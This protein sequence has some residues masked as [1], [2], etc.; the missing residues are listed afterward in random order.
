MIRTWQ[1]SWFEEGLRLFY[2]LPRAAVDAVLPLTIN[3]APD[4][5]T[6]VFV[7]RAELITPDM[8]R[9]ALE[10]VLKDGADPV[11]AGKQL[12]TFGRFRNVVLGR[13]YPKTTDEAVRKRIAS[14][15]G[16]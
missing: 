14:L 1:D 12:A 6:R 9:A 10:I 15:M 8:E 5:V 7:G 3:P 2:I 4:E 16:E 13:L 11:A